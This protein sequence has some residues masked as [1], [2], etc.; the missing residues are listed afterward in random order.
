LRERDLGVILEGAQITLNEY[1][2]RWRETAVKPRVRE[3]TYQD[4]EDMVRR[5]IR[6]NLWE[7]LLGLSIM[8]LAKPSSALGGR[9]EQTFRNNAG[10]GWRKRVGVETASKR[11]IKDLT[12]RGQP[13]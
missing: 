2:D 3:K 1:L 6:P 8:P 13:S 9:K 11:Q 4:Y 7:S 10:S 12:R 5:Y